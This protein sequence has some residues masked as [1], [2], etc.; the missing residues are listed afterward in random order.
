MK[1][2][3]DERINKRMIEMMGIMQMNIRKRNLNLQLPNMGLR[4][5]YLPY[6]E[7]RV[8]ELER[9]LVWALFSISNYIEWIFSLW[10][11]LCFQWLFDI[12]STVVWGSYTVFQI[13]LSLHITWAATKFVCMKQV[14]PF[15]SG[16]RE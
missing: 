7:D 8:I 4:S 5:V 9:S 13:S 11:H 10:N 12:P 16:I 15:Q 3:I 1:R 6:L 2:M 14:W